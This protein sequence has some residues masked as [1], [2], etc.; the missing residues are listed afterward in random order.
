MIEAEAEGAEDASMEGIVDHVQCIQLH[1][2][3]VARTVKYLS[4]QLVTNQFSVVTVSVK[5][6]VVVKDDFRIVDHD[7]L[8]QAIKLSL[9]KSTE[10][11]TPSLSF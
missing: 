6:V 4:D 11:S 10:S 7:L 8:A 2:Q 1:V 9:T 3:N 5:T